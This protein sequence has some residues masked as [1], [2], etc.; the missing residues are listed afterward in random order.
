MKFANGDVRIFSSPVLRCLRRFKERTP[1]LFGRQHILLPCTTSS[2]GF[3]PTDGKAVTDHRITAGGHKD[4]GFE[5]GKDVWIKFV[6]P[7]QHV[8]YFCLQ[9]K[10]GKLDASGATHAP[11][12]NIAEI[13]SQMLMMLD[14]EVFDPELSKRV[15]VDHAFM[16][17]GG[18]ICTINATPIREPPLACSQIEV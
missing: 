18:V 3:A 14:H 8:F 15:L 7:T 12:R 1:E 4:K 17:A 6:L 10:K 11:N 5:Y 13:Y 16:V 2:D 9:A